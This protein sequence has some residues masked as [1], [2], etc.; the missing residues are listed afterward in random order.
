MSYFIFSFN[1]KD[2]QYILRQLKYDR[3][4]TEKHE[5]KTQGNVKSGVVHGYME[6]LFIGYND[7]LW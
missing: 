7:T 3:Y 2:T 6:I 5:L 4:E 1:T